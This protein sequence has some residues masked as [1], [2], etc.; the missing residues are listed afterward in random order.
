M[1][2]MNI[3]ILFTLVFIT[4]LLSF[5][6]S[7]NAYLPSEANKEYAF[8]LNKGINKDTIQ[9]GKIS[10]TGNIKIKIPEKEKGYKGI[11]SLL[12][13]G[14][15]P[16]NLIINNENF[17]LE[18]DTTTR[19]YKF[20]ESKEND[21]L[22]SIMQDGKIPAIDTTLYASHFIDLIRF[23]QQLNRVT[24]Q[25][26][27]LM[28]RANARIYALDKMDMES[29]YTSSIWHNAI[30]A[31]T[32]LSVSEEAFG[33]DMIRLLKRIQPQEVFEHLADN[34]ITITEQY[35]WDDAFDIIVP[36]IKESGR[37]EF[38]QGNMYAAFA[39]AKIQKGTLAPDIE[40]LETSLKSSGAPLTLLV[41]YQPDCE[42]CHIQINRLIEDYPR[43]KQMGVRIISISA[44]SEKESYE[45]DLK[46]FP[47]NKEDILCDFEGF[48][49]KNIITYGIMSTPTF[50]LIDKD[51]KIIKRYALLSDI[52]FTDVNE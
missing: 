16:L 13:K 9:Q 21:F 39:L 45:N 28:E 51:D 36:Y 17:H 6:Q 5:G 11:G 4:P 18:Q 44:D 52:R 47:W 23:M 22:Y 41:F 7:I 42:N 49:G 37:I 32:R 1:M 34:L 27:D 31:L 43:L 8:T 33:N 24:T 2:K 30:D 25:N 35:G 14:N 29:L 40:G 20:K 26:V 48:A 12:I 3:Y 10:V 50:F 38:P 19:K 15:N 46:R